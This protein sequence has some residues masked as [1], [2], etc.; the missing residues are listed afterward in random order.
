M[1]N[2]TASPAT[3]TATLALGFVRLASAIRGSLGRTARPKAIQRPRRTPPQTVG[4]GMIPE[5]IHP[6]RD[7]ALAGG[8]HTAPRVG[9]PRPS[10][11]VADSF[12]AT[13]A[14]PCA[15]ASTIPGPLADADG[16]THARSSGHHRRFSC[17][18]AASAGRPRIAAKVSNVLV[19]GRYR[20]RDAS[21]PRYGMPGNSRPNSMDS[22]TLG[23]VVAEFAESTTNYHTQPPAA[24]LA[25]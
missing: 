16:Q 13:C 15:Q 23:E 21:R 7:R 4:F 19:L 5:A 18:G 3:A 6:R 14:A 25:R 20:P 12:A 11:D 9:N 2:R 24:L 8:V 17:F 10:S 22:R 1:A